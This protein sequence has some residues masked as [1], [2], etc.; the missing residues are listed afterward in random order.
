MVIINETFIEKYRPKNID[1]M[2]GIDKEFFR[3][4]VNEPLKFPHILLYSTKPGTGKTS[5]SK[6]LIR[7]LGADSLIMNASDE[8]KI[9]DIRDKIKRF[10][11]TKSMK[12][13]IPKI[14]LLDEVDGMLKASQE[15]LRSLMENYPARFILTCNNIGD[16][17]EPIQSRCQVINMQ[18]PNKEEII[19]KLKEICKLEELELEED[20][21]KLLC[22]KEYPSIRNM[23]N[24]LYLFKIK[25]YKKILVS[26]MNLI[27]NKYIDI[28]D[29]VLQNKLTLA[30]KEWL[31]NGYPLKEVLRYFFDQVMKDLPPAIEFI[32]D[33]I[34]RTEISMRDNTDKDIIMFDFIIKFR[35]LIHIGE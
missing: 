24:N 22:D 35:K 27:R 25:G 2:V 26:D 21:Y 11:E 20:A 14:V 9:D 8:R 32:I 28:Y 17:I 3:K 29:L 23:L 16:I 19:K 10:V 33:L 30:R 12:Q 7:E 13:N 4:I 18:L 5:L 15:A 34:A 6:V 31:E 1:N